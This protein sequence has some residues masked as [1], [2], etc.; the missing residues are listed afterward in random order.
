MAKVN[1]SLETPKQVFFQEKPGSATGGKQGASQ[2][3]HKH[4]PQSLEL[5]TNIPRKDRM[6]VTILPTD[7]DFIKMEKY[8]ER[9]LADPKLTID[10]ILQD[11]FT[12]HERAKL[13]P[14]NK[15]PM[16]K[17]QEK[18]TIS[19]NNILKGRF[20]GKLPTLACKMAMHYFG[21]VVAPMKMLPS[22]VV[23]P[24][25][26]DDFRQ[27]KVIAKDPLGFL[28]EQGKRTYSNTPTSKKQAKMTPLVGSM[29]LR[30][31]GLEEDEA[32]LIISD[33][34]EESSED[35]E[36]QAN[37]QLSHSLRGGA[38]DYDE[39]PIHIQYK[40]NQSEETYTMYGRQGSA[41][42]AFKWKDF[43]E[44]AT[45]LLTDAADRGTEIRIGIDLFDYDIYGTWK[46]VDTIEGLFFL[47]IEEYEK[48]PEDEIY[49]FVMKNMT[50]EHR[51]NQGRVCFV[52]YG[53]EQQPVSPEPDLKPGSG[54]V[55]LAHG[56]TRDR[57]VVYMRTPS[58]PSVFNSTTQYCM[59]FQKAIGALFPGEYRHRWIELKQARSRHSYGR[60]YAFQDPPLEF[61]KA[62]G[63]SGTDKSYLEFLIVSEQLPSDIIPVIVPG[64][65]A[66]DA[67]LA[68][69]ASL[70][71]RRLLTKDSLHELTTLV[72]MTL[73]DSIHYNRKPEVSGLRIWFPAQNFF[74][75]LAP[76]VFIGLQG[77][78]LAANA[79]ALW[80]EAVN[81]WRSSNPALYDAGI[82]IVTQPLYKNYEVAKRESTPSQ[83]YAINFPNLL[84]S[85]LAVF[86]GMME[87]LLYAGRYD[88]DD[89]N[90][91]LRT[92]GYKILSDHPIRFDTTEKEWAMFRR[93]ITSDQ[94][95]VDLDDGGGKYQ[96][97]MK[98][99]WD[100]DGA[101]YWGPCY[102]TLV[103]PDAITH[104][105]SNQIPEQ[106]PLYSIV[107]TESLVPSGNIE[108]Q[109]SWQAAFSAA[110]GSHN[111]QTQGLNNTH[112]THQPPSE[113]SLDFSQPPPNITN[114]FGTTQSQSTAKPK[115]K[116][117]WGKNVY[118]L[119]GQVSDVAMRHQTYWNPPSIFSNVLKP[120]V[121]LHAAPMESMLRTGPSVPAVSLAMRTPT[122]MARLEREV[123]KLRAIALDRMRECPYADCDVFFHYL[124]TEELNRH[125]TD[126]HTT[127]QCAFC[128]AL[129]S[130]EN[131]LMLQG[132]DSAMQ[133]FRERHWE[134]FLTLDQQ[135]KDGKPIKPKG[136]PSGANPSKPD[137]VKSGQGNAPRK[138][139]DEGNPFC[140]RCG[141]HLELI[142]LF[143][144]EVNHKQ[145]CTYK[146]P[147]GY[148]GDATGH[149][150]WCQYCG[151]RD[152]NGCPK[153][154]CPE[155]IRLSEGEGPWPPLLFCHTCGFHWEGMGKLAIS[156]HTKHC[157]PPGGNNND[158]CGF[159]GIAMHNLEEKMKRQH[160]DSCKQRTNGNTTLSTSKPPKPNGA[161][162]AKGGSI[163]KGDPNGG[164]KKPSN[165]KPH[166]FD[167]D[168][169]MFDVGNG[170][171]TTLETSESEEAAAPVPGGHGSPNKRK[172]HSTNSGDPSYRKTFRDGEPD[173]E[174]S[175]D[176]D[177]DW[178]SPSKA[179][180]HNNKKLPPRPKL[181]GSVGEAGQGSPPAKKVRIAP[182]AKSST[183]AATPVA[184]DNDAEPELFSSGKFRAKS[185]IPVPGGDGDKG[186]NPRPKATPKTKG[187]KITI[188]TEGDVDVDIQ[189]E[190]TGPSTP[191][192]SSSMPPPPAPNTTTRKSSRVPK[193]TQ[194]KAAYQELDLTDSSAGVVETPTSADTDGNF[195]PENKKAPA[196]PAVKTP[197]K[198]PAKRG[199]KKVAA[200]G[201]SMSEEE[202]KWPKPQPDVKTPRTTGRLKAAPK[203]KINISDVED[204]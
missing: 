201:N 54:L 193:S 168:E 72:R 116:H 133:H 30:G 104:N 183:R 105:P 87:G 161:K 102:V 69:E 101:S 8:F 93:R 112:E 2:Q 175:E 84:D 198:T 158:Y 172:R 130:K 167:V 76:S 118:S 189:E 135:L 153:E 106:P 52:R 113:P 80:A 151:S 204:A 15:L 88:L 31:G 22:Q 171:E 194:K 120:V 14:T 191:I 121:P 4:K 90:H 19:F 37:D 103:D 58:T 100:A 56:K 163:E 25:D 114:Y 13:L 141:R 165:K 51:I 99:R 187:K 9:L 197:S 17:W 42:Y 3:K 140:H 115:E 49:N 169:V 78:V 146:N 109:N 71:K 144:D 164:A 7:E 32:K 75:D 63:K 129:G 131:P 122:E 173:E 119:E 82:A 91:V 34:D 125:L 143:T 73:E 92:V 147:I 192:P 139:D 176:E 174:D 94:L 47:D 137:P 95:L 85:N 154:D 27:E 77:G 200:D 123:H 145:Q 181:T 35:W 46:C 70:E 138:P 44:A 61:V 38:L 24:A 62:I 160:W 149:E 43:V 68:A 179:T 39:L 5:K 132:G 127:V 196:R 59:E 36:S 185:S 83:R 136:Q 10:Q 6:Q 117:A 67:S 182:P 157:K 155:K 12:E 48:R 26:F 86:K 18:N 28:D 124:D 203:K 29:N 188:S 128:L 177:G 20:K 162:A 74:S 79:L 45:F 40:E 108:P 134:Q 107:S 21:L 170:D 110:L 180:F 57:R 152:T 55:S 166:L 1:S 33:V 150:T 53:G 96:W 178:K 98:T 60:I 41:R 16:A 11:H 156:A 142:S 159:C 111:G 190:S 89:K 148:N 50:V 23:D 126:T 81:T 66:P 65:R 184:V 202:P 64:A 199:R 195:W 186:K 97:E